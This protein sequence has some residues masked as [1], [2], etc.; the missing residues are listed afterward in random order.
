MRNFPWFWCA[1]ML[2]QLSCCKP[3]CCSSRAASWQAC[4]PVFAPFTT[5]RGLIADSAQI[6]RGHDTT[7]LAPA[8]HRAAQQLRSSTRRKQQQS[9][10]RATQAL[11]GR[12]A[13]IAANSYNAVMPPTSTSEGGSTRHGAAAADCHMRSTRVDGYEICEV[14]RPRRV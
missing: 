7:R 6:V 13:H 14:R 12:Q 11:A 3:I 10:A 9:Q 4:Q 1:A 5:F 2:T 8:A